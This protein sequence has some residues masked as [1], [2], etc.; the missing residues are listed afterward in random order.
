MKNI[1]VISHLPDVWQ[2][3]SDTLSGKATVSHTNALADALSCHEKNQSDIIF[4]DLDLLLASV[5]TGNYREAAEPFSK[6]NPLVQIIVL[7]TKE[8][9]R[10]AVSV[11]RGGA[12]DYLTYPIDEKE[13]LL[14]FNSVQETAAKDLELDY[15]RDRFWKSEWLDIIRTRNPAM[16]KFYDHIRSVAPTIATVLLMG[17]TGTGKGLMA[18]LIHLHSLRNEKPFV[19]VHCGAIPDTLLESELFGH[20][21]GAF[22][23]ADRRKIGRFELARGGTIFLDEIGTVTAPAQIKLLQVLQDGTFS[24]VGGNDLLKTDA[25][26]I[27]ATN[28]DLKELVE[29]RQFRKDLYYR[30]NVFPVEI[31][32]LKNRLEDLPY[33]VDI[34]TSKLNDRYGRRVSGLHPDVQ[35]GMRAYDWPGNIRELE[36]II[37]RA[38]IVE[39]SN[40]LNPWS[41]P[42]E[43]VAAAPVVQDSP[44]HDNWSLAQSRKLAMDQFESVYLKRLLR[45]FKGKINRSAEKAEITPRQLNRLMV[46]HGLSK[47][48]F[49]S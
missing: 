11:V 1:L 17:E 44:A 26:I 20:E 38:F 19:V 31:P 35:A 43:L 47:N 24:R 33:L 13:V 2:L 23:G 16:R 9:V 10:E 29:K 48:D 4:Y 3:I 34:F 5:P 15:L 30:L 8:A 27:A 42:I 41:F 45:R 7:T 32:P 25:R 14:V 39:K 40:V 18:R 37:E 12:S 49:K 6:V 21:R 28:E 22:T 36:N 46:R